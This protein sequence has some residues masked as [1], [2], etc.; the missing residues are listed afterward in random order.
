VLPGRVCD[1]WF[2]ATKP[3]KYHLFC[4]EYCGTQHSGMIGWI[5]VLDPADY[6]AW[7]AGTVASESPEAAG[8]RVFES[9]RCDSCHLQADQPRGPPLAGVY[10]R[11]VKTKDGR[12]ILA[13]ENY[14]RESILRPLTDVVAGYEPLMPPYEGLVNEE[15]LGDLVAWL[16][17]Q[18]A[19]EPPR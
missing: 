11:T 16:K 7:L 10:G 19:P 13:D 4:A 14:L 15:Q 6:A 3:G 12:T 1:A 17:S 9:L 8:R 18:P 5:H 2:E